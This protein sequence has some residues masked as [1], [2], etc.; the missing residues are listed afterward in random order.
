MRKNLPK[1]GFRT[2][3]KKH[4]FLNVAQKNKNYKKTF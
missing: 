4:G 2:N 3:K 1:R